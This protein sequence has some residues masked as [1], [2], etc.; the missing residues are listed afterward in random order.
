MQQPHMHRA[1]VSSARVVTQHP[2]INNQ[3][4]IKPKS[5]PSTVSS[6]D[7]FHP[8][9]SNASRLPVCLQLALPRAIL[10][11]RCFCFFLIEPS[12]HPTDA[13]LVSAHLA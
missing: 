13:Y 5:L 9:L 1:D 10:G 3:L 12:E 11:A 8:G 4:R 2:G 7:P 6:P